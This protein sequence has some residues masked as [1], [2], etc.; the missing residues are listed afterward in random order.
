M[1]DLSPERWKEID[2]LFTE[3]LELDSK[4]REAILAERC[5]EDE[6]LRLA[7]ERLLV[8]DSRSGNFLIGSAETLVSDAFEEALRQ[9]AEDLDAT[10][11]SR[12]GERIGSWRLVREI[13]RGG[14]ARVFLAERAD[15]EFQHTVAVKLI[16][17]GLDTED[18]IE[19]F[20]AE[21][22]ILSSLRHPNIA[23]LIGGG[24]TDDGLPYLVLEYVDGQPIT[25]YCDEHRLSVATRLE[26]FEDAARAVQ[27]AH[28]NL[29]V[30][31]DIKP[32]NILVTTDGVVKLLDFG[33]AKLLDP[34]AAP[35]NVALTRTGH[36]PLTP[37]YAS[38]EQVRGD[39][40]TTASDVYQLGVLLYR[41]LTGERPYDV[42]G[43]G[44]ELEDAITGS[45]PT[46]PSI[47]AGRL[48]AEEAARKGATPGRLGRLLRGDL[49]V[50]VLKAL[51]KVPGRRYGSA[52]EMAEDVRRHRQGRPILAR[53]ESR[54]YRTRKFLQRNTWFA[55]VAAALFLL[56]GL[57]VATLIRHGHELEEER[58]V[59]RDVKE[60]F[61]S[62]FTAPEEV[63]G[64][65][66]GEG[67]R[68]I[69]V[70]EAIL[71]GAD[72]V[73]AELADRPAARAE[74][75][76][77]MAEVLND[78]DEQEHAH[79]L[80]SEALA[81]EERLYGEASPEIEETL[82]LVGR[83]HPDA[84]SARAFLERRLELG[85]T[86]YGEN[87]PRVANSLEHLAMVETDPAVASQLLEKS[88]EILRQ[89]RDTDLVTP[90]SLA[91][92]L[93]RLAQ[94]YGGLG[95]HEDAVTV[96]REAYDL[97]LGYLGEDH[98]DTALHGVKLAGALGAVG[99][100]EEARRLFEASLATLDEE[101]GPAHATTITSRGNYA[102][103][104][105]QLEDY[106]A[107]EATQRRLVEANRER[108]GDVSPSTA[109]A[110]QNLA[111]TAKLRGRYAEAD[112]LLNAAFERYAATHGEVHYLTAFPLLTMAEIRL[113]TGDYAG[114]E[115]AAGRAMEILA[116]ALPAGHYA[117]AV[118]ECRVGMALVG[119]GRVEEGRPLL[120]HAASILQAVDVARIADH[121]TACMEAAA[122]L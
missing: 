98:S 30:H 39:P 20:R 64:S 22:Q 109:A 101:L 29:V 70:R 69:T 92:S 71:E 107:A 4:Q 122:A 23:T 7:V 42:T 31:R 75:F 99:R 46:M 53:R 34:D 3:V 88:V 89:H 93:G 91:F 77:A 104:L 52:V 27:Y 14:M 41:L 43:P 44:R 108:F 68:D 28:A 67:R 102:L 59:A 40:I 66:L 105:V 119:Q 17:R 90:R 103:V 78:L 118:A 9:G 5:V 121:R 60:A 63:D 87:H 113:K 114:A 65:G 24:T 86:L 79:Q 32:S 96:S 61:V 33:I 84:D 21:R 115:D 82:W 55:P 57:Y 38:P 51:R 62:F 35:S 8:A 47:A 16:R 112:S 2:D 81:I 116:D 11:S 19:R 12:I 54:L 26:L 110:L 37:E 106:A 36:R 58:N 56:I 48:A 111:V 18:F 15:G 83:L 95:R 49:D 1:S 6:D 120:Y 10:R 73:R 45:Q 117:T 50:I 76:G 97:M 80:A 100:V 85:R 94:V 74:L 25:D 13:G 72:R